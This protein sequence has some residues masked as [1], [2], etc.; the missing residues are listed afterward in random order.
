MVRV[1]AETRLIACAAGAPERRPRTIRELADGNR[2]RRT[3]RIRPA[4]RGTDYR[5]LAHAVLSGQR[6]D[7]YALAACLADHDNGFIGELCTAVRGTRYAF[8]RDVWPDGTPLN[9]FRR[10]PPAVRAGLSE[11]CLLRRDSHIRHI[12]PA[13]SLQ[14]VGR[15]DQ[16][17]R[18]VVHERDG[19]VALAAEETAELARLMV[20]VNAQAALPPPLPVPVG[21]RL[22]AD[23]AETVVIL[24]VLD[25]QVRVKAVFDGGAPEVSHL[26]PFTVFPV[27][28]PVA[29]VN[30]FRIILV[31]LVRHLADALLAP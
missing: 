22:P 6:G 15:S 10:S 19:K 25:H 21:G 9:D 28:A 23:V 24:V 8:G 20:V 16:P 4:L 1:I 29:G 11:Q 13:G 30:I 5:C 26:E 12:A 2:D 18:V 31:P 7:R 27:P 14:V 3:A 17:L